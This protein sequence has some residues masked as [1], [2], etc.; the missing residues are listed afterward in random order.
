[1]QCPY[2][3]L[4]N[5]AATCYMN[6]YLQYL[7]LHPE[8]RSLL[9]SLELRPSSE[10]DEKDSIPYQLQ[11]LFAKLN[12]GRNKQASTKQLT[13]AFQW[14]ATETFAEHDVSEFAKI[15][16]KAISESLDEK[17]RDCFKW[18]E[19]LSEGE[20]ISFVECKGCGGKSN[21]QQIF[22][23]IHLVI[24]NE[25]EKIYCRKLESSLLENIKSVRLDGDNKF[26]CDSCGTKQDAE[27]GSEYKRFP[28]I[29][30]FNLNRFVFDYQTMQRQK[31]DD[32]F[33]FPLVIDLDGFLGT[34]KEVF[35]RQ[36]GHTTGDVPFEKEEV[37]KASKISKANH[38]S[39]QNVLSTKKGKKFKNA[40]SSRGTRNFLRQMRKNK[41][42]GDV[43]VE[44]LMDS[45]TENKIKEEV[46]SKTN[47]DKLSDQISFEPV[48][49]NEEVSSVNL[50]E[51]KSPMP[52][53]EQPTFDIEDT[54]K[55]LEK[56][57]S[58]S[59]NNDKTTTK[60]ITKNEL[61][62]IDQK[63]SDL[64]EIKDQND[65]L[66]DNLYS[67]QAVF[68]HKG[69]AYSGHYYVYI[70]SFETGIWYLFDDYQVQEVTVTDVL[71][72][73]FG[74]HRLEISAYMLAYRRK[75]LNKEVNNDMKTLLSQFNCPDYLAKIIDDEMKKEEALQKKKFK[76]LKKK[77]I[78]H[79]V[80]Y[81][82]ETLMVE[83]SGGKTFREFEK[84]CFETFNIPEEERT[85]CRLRL[86]N[87]FKDEM[88][89]D[90][91]EK[92]D[93]KLEKLK[94]HTIKSFIFEVKKPD[95]VFKKYNPDVLTIK[96][97][98]W[99]EKAECIDFEP[100]FKNIEIDKNSIVKDLVSKIREKFL[101]EE[102]KSHVINLILKHTF[103]NGIIKPENCI[104]KEDKKLSDLY[105]NNSTI[106]YIDHHK[107]EEKT[108][109]STWFTFFENEND[110]I[111][112]NFNYPFEENSTETKI[113]YN[114][115]MKIDLKS[116]VRDLKERFR[117]FFKIPPEVDFIIKKGG[118]SGIE[119]KDFNKV[120]RTL[121]I[122]NNSF[123]FLI[124]GESTSVNEIKANFFLCTT[125]LPHNKYSL[126]RETV[127]LKEMNINPFLTPKKILE[128]I[129]SKLPDVSPLLLS[130]VKEQYEGF[131]F[132]SISKTLLNNRA[133]EKCSNKVLLNPDFTR[134][135]EKNGD[136]LTKCFQNY[137]LKNQGVGERKRLIL[138]PFAPKL[139]NNQILV[140]FTELNCKELSFSPVK[141]VIVDK[142]YNLREFSLALIDEGLSIPI[143]NLEATKIRDVR[144]FVIEDVLSHYFT[145]M[146]KT[147]MLLSSAPYYLETDGCLF[148]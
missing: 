15:L 63:N 52:P 112:L 143:D 62:G 56:K 23:E 141:E 148:M 93:W 72:D 48:V 135:R 103:K 113:D 55:E 97:V 83:T 124:F 12:L 71:K 36:K 114:H 64:P 76:A 101:K 41:K 92:K 107:E 94:L 129:Y 17:R 14:G 34:Q 60:N 65:N 10:E 40:K 86:Y 24:R 115:K 89:K 145:D 109:K 18:V 31:L 67:L 20:S 126:E 137:S 95:E 140:Y 99:T 2:I 50:T 69:S 26:H 100:E 30:T 37:S 87:K 27:K 53:L 144:E 79:R 108:K 146:S 98:F 96:L 132:S 6:S 57:A 138:E 133:I 120:L 51:A 75:K 106:I 22:S 11:K 33:E 116:T 147:D 45:T 104:N 125:R 68:I 119:M 21:T 13:A 5:Q 84:D 47:T 81:K 105:I 110:K 9:F 117:E 3:G 88:L 44:F 123:L 128:Q 39:S 19:G 127:F 46:N 73:G 28:D 38:K 80:F 102:E 32:Y 142:K 66:P 70:K 77:K 16:A 58:N 91:E 59:Q 136:I 42:G 130:A 118:K 111:I 25:W 82:L 4:I 49:K 1:M 78:K 74:G 8:F 29:V 61:L 54:N 43:K 121:R 131:D 134:I 122:I 85:N 90:F 35:E 139:E 7:Y